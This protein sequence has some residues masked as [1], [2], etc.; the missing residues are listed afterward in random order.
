[1]LG[2]ILRFEGDFTDSRNHLETAKGFIEEFKELDFDKDRLDLTCDYADTLRELG[3]LEL[4]ESLLRAELARRDVHCISSKSPL[5]LALAE[6]LFAQGQ[7]ECADK[8]CADIESRGGLLKL[9]R[10]RL[11]ITIAKIRHSVSDKPRAFESWTK[12]LAGVRKFTLTNG[13]T[14]RIIML[15]R[16]E[17]LPDTADAEADA[18]WSLKQVHFL[19]QC[20]KPEGTKYWIAGLGQWAQS[21]EFIDILNGPKTS[22][23]EEKE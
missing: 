17:V 14:T 2:R 3:E 22:T 23:E 11:Y 20:A 15:S 7:L 4:A 9:E 16:R 18:E 12:A 21:R 13:Y 8:I 6:V 5:K 1:M 19:H 10:L